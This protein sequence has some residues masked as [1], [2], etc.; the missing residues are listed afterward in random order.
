MGDGILVLPAA[1]K[2]SINNRISLDPKILAMALDIEAPMVT[3]FRFYAL[4]PC[5][6]GLL[7]AIRRGG[8]AA[9][10]VVMVAADSLV[11]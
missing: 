5:D 9:L 6:L 11:C 10:V 2:P 3:A 4:E 8:L 7:V 1:S